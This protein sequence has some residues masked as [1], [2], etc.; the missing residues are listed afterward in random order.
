[1]WLIYPR[2]GTYL[3]AKRNKNVVHIPAYTQFGKYFKLSDRMMKATNQHIPQNTLDLRSYKM[4][5]PA[6]S[7]ETD[8][9]TIEQYKA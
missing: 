9:L 2:L 6:C 1:M 8:Q 3:F 5:P 4:L 7:L